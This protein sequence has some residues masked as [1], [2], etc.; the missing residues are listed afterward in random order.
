MALSLEEESGDGA[1]KESPR[2]M[3]EVGGNKD[4]RQRKDLETYIPSGWPSHVQTTHSVKSG[5]ANNLVWNNGVRSYGEVVLT[6]PLTF[7]KT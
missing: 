4:H 2:M 5:Q 3:N 7:A 1:R 6:V